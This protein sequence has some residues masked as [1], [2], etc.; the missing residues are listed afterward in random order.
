MFGSAQSKK[1]RASSI[2][3]NALATSNKTDI[4]RDFQITLVVQGIVL[5][6][7]GALIAEIVL[8]SHPVSMAW[9]AAV[10]GISI[11]AAAVYRLRKNLNFPARLQSQLARFAAEPNNPQESLHTIIDQQKAGQGWN[12]LVESYLEITSDRSIERRITTVPGAIGNERYA[13]ALRSLPEGVAI[14]DRDGNLAYANAAWSC[15]AQPTGHS[16]PSESNERKSISDVLAA[17]GYENWGVIAPHLLEG[18]RPNKWELHLGPGVHDGVMRLERTPMD[19]RKGEDEGFVWTLRDITQS[20]IAREAH[21]QFLASATHELRTPL[22]NIR[23]YSESLVEMDGITPDQQK[24]FFNVI[25]SESGRLGRLLNQL[26]DIQQ[27]EAGSM[28]INVAKF[29][30]HRMMNEIQEYIDPLIKEKQLCF[31]ARIAP[32]IKA[33]DA[34]KEKMTSCLVNLLGNAVKYTPA[35]GDVRLIAEQSEGSLLI[36]VEDTG[37][38]IAPEE[39]S[40]I[41][42]RFYRCQDDRIVDTEGNGL[43]LAFSQEVAR[44][45]GGELKVESQINEGSRFTLAIPLRPDES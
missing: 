7:V 18:T 24:E 34:D 39:Q 17:V 42:D 2:A 31:T 25:H 22:T 16:Q 26:L 3:G 12:R 19:G 37:I 45:H 1:Q 44:L 10:L 9:V 38:G 20:A 13:R 21:E 4:V 41:F 5:M 15:S 32:D 28:T 36:A 29:D 14:T 35:G 6:L 27:L 30:I 23:A 8:S 11:A 33:I 40:K 43:G